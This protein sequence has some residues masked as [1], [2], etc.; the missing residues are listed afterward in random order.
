MNRSIVMFALLASG[1]CAPSYPLTATVQAVATQNASVGGAAEL[2]VNVTNT[3][4][5]ISHLGLVFRTPD[6]WYERHEMTDL[7]GCSIAADASA[8]DCGALAPSETKSYSLHGI[9]KSAGSYHFELALRELVHPFNYVNDHPDGADSQ[10][11][12]E[13]VR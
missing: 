13:T 8:F 3:G 5:A 2:L 10:V 12:D 4:P 11:W 6:R 7:G 9:A 1:F